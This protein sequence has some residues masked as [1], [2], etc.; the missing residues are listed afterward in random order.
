MNRTGKTTF[1]ALIYLAAISTTPA[2]AVTIANPTNTLGLEYLSGSLTGGNQTQYIGQ[3]FTAPITGN[4]TDFQFTL[5]QSDLQSL[6]GVVF[7]WN[8]TSPTTE[9][10]RSAVVAGAAGLIDFSPTNVQLTQGQTYVAF[11]STYGLQNNAGMATVGTC[12]T[13]GGCTSNKTPNLGTLIIG[14]ILDGGAVFNPIV[15]NSR[16]A[17]FSATISAVSAAPEPATWGM[18]ILGMFTVGVA[19][20]RRQNVTTRVSYSV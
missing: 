1:A 14:N 8:G 20:R 17:T 7:A 19:L 10:W 13:F 5:N 18:M 9:L 12:L 2:S 11:L 15:N 3:T 4:L 6:Y 16:D